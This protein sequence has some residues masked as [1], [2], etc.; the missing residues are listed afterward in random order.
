VHAVGYNKKNNRAQ[1]TNRLSPQK[2]EARW[3]EP[4]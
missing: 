1:R 3:D 2:L 4:D